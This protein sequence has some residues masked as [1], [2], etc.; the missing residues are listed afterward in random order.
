MQAANYLAWRAELEQRLAGEEPEP[1]AAPGDDPLQNHLLAVLARARQ[2]AAAINATLAGGR[3]DD[4][5]KYHFLSER[6]GQIVGFE[7]FSLAE[8]TYRL[9]GGKR[10]GAR[11]WLSEERWQ[12][13]LG[14]M[15]FEQVGSWQ[16]DGQGRKVSRPLLSLDLN[17]P[18]PQPLIEGEVSKYYEPG[19]EW[20]KCL[21]EALCLP[22]LFY[23]D[24]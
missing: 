21:T 20:Q 24:L 3:V 7:S 1:L 23:H 12:R 2:V 10:P 18:Q 9:A 17:G 16:A 13:Y 8:Y 22:V 6:L 19:W 5:N 14:V 11:L 4:L 15:L